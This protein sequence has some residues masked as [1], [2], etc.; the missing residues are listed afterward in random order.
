MQFNSITILP[1]LLAA[2]FGNA[3]VTFLNTGTTPSGWDATNVEHLGT[4]QQVTNVVYR[5]GTAIKATQTWDQA[6]ANAGNR[7]HSEVVHNDGY[8]RGETKSYGFA[9]RLQ[10]DWD[11]GSSQSYNIAQFIADFSDFNSACDDWVPTTMVWLQGNQLYSRVKS[12][13]DICNQHTNVFGNL[14]AV[15]PGV[16][17]TVVIE[18]NWQSDNTGYFKLWFD[19]QQVLSKSGIPTTVPVG[20]EIEFRVGL[21]ANGWGDQKTNVGGQNTRQVWYDQIATG[22]TAADVNP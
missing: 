1:L 3:A 11:F 7:F 6:W 2:G 4:L 17:H 5:G 8:H 16:W 19:G 14:A 18:A 12:W 10:E 20:R 13:T 22:T 15:S 9:F 21:Y